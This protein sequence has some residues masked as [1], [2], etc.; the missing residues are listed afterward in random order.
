[1][2]QHAEVWQHGVRVAHE[3][4]VQLLRHPRHRDV[5]AQHRLVGLCIQL[6]ADQ[7]AGD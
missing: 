4:R 6:Q 2:Y 1:M 7:H 5:T 3:Q